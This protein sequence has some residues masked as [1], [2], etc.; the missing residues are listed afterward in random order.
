MARLVETLWTHVS[1]CDRAVDPAASARFDDD[2]I[3][4]QL[5]GKR[6]GNTPLKVVFSTLFST[7]LGAFAMLPLVVIVFL[8][9]G[10]LAEWVGLVDRA[11]ISSEVS[12]ALVTSA[13]L[14]MWLI[15]G[16]A[17]GSMLSFVSIKKTRP[18]E[19]QRQAPEN[20]V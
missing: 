19:I 4:S 8:P 20:S 11:T 15:V 18:V 10:K 7:G 1:K 2:R 12:S 16:I 6:N 5:G 13:M 9:L 14:F 3:I 17:I